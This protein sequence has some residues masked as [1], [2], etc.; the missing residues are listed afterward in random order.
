V[1]GFPGRISRAAFG[2]TMQD[3][4][5]IRNPNTDFGASLVNL[6]LWQ[7]AGMNGITPRGFQLCTISG[8]VL[9][10]GR[11]WLAWDA[12]GALPASA[13]DVVRSGTGVYTW[14]LS[15]STYADKDGTMVSVAIDTVLV[16]P[17]GTTNLNMIADVNANGYQGTA[18]AFTADS[19]AVADPAKFALILI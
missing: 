5:R 12:D 18:N 11:K 6:L 3:E 1:A 8:G 14:A 16:F 10:K 17:M 2:P 19:G 13:F 15:S 7:V 4:G 9:S